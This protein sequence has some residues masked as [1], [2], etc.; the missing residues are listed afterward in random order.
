MV[1][2]ANDDLAMPAS[3]VANLRNRTVS[4][5]LGMTGPEDLSAVPKNVYEVD[6]DNFNNTFDKPVGH[7]YFLD[8]PKKKVSPVLKHMVQAIKK[9]RVIPNERP[10]ELPKP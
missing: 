9:G 6:C 5:R 1:Y 10:H 3:K 4:R 8:G 7:A 2:Y